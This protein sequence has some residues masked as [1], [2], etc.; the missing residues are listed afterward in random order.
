[1]GDHTDQMYGNPTLCPNPTVEGKIMGF[2]IKNGTG[3]V[4]VPPFYPVARVYNLRILLLSAIGTILYSGFIER[5]SLLW[6]PVQCQAAF[7]CGVI[8]CIHHFFCCFNWR[9]PVRAGITVI[10]ILLVMLEAGTMMQS[11]TEIT[12]QRFTLLGYCAAAYPL[13][14]LL[15]I[16]LN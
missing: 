3:R 1:M 13:Y 8:I 9:M 14:N 16:L 2:T 15:S 10:D 4:P 12:K 5:G 11:T 6:S 7:T